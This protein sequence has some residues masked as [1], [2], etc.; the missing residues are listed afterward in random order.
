M[1]PEQRKHTKASARP[2]CVLICSQLNLQLKVSQIDLHY[3][4]LLGILQTGDKE[5]AVANLSGEGRV[6]DGFH[7]LF[8]LL[9]VD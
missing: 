9:I 2:G 7:R 4:V 8:T 3:S 5:L 6:L 1:R